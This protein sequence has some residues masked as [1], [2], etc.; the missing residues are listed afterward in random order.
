M[1]KKKQ[2]KGDCPKCTGIMGYQHES[3]VFCD[4][5]AYYECRDCGFIID[6]KT[7]KEL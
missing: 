1:S 5:G 6:P 3:C 4:G 7:G 2:N